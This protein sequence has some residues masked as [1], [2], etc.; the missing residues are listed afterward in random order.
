MLF[1]YASLLLREIKIN[2]P[3]YIS[4]F[5]FYYAWTLMRRGELITKKIRI[6]LLL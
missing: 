4:E 6:F 3:S 5:Y 2:C 1:F